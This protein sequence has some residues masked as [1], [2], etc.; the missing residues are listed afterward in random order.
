MTAAQSNLFTPKAPPTKATESC[1]VGTARGM[2]SRHGRSVEGT[3]VLS[4]PNR[5]RR[6][7]ATV[8]YDIPRYWGPPGADLEVNALKLAVFWFAHLGGL[9]VIRKRHLCHLV[10]R[11]REDAETYSWDRIGWAMRHYFDKMIPLYAEAFADSPRQLGD[12]VLKR[13]DADLDA[14]EQLR[15]ATQA[16]A[17]APAPAKRTWTET[18][19]LADG[20]SKEM[21]FGYTP[22]LAKPGP[23]E[24][25]Q[26]DAKIWTEELRDRLWLA[27]PPRQQRLIIDSPAMR[28]AL[29]NVCCSDRA[30][31]SPQDWHLIREES[32]SAC[33]RAGD[34]LA[35]GRFVLALRATLRFYRKYEK[36]W[37]L[38]P[39]EQPAEPR[40]AGAYAGEMTA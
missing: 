38:R 7:R 36:L 30:T 32:R 40:S 31:F 19:S 28:S 23:A 21:V 9:A 14:C 20:T 26:P 25:E 5:S 13:L 3:V 11:M 1:E 18:V 24:C 27:I 10:A 17:A 2:L 37:N 35:R 12:W 33:Q 4:K 39:T 22:P 29:A 34:R 15:E 6:S 16:R 8:R